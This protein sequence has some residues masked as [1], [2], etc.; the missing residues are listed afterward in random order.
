[1]TFGRRQVLAM[2]AAGQLTTDDADR[3]ITALDRLDEPGRALAR[4]TPSATPPRYLRV[5]IDMHEEGEAQSKVNA[6]VPLRVLRAGGTL[7]PRI[8]PQAPQEL[9][10][11]TG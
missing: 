4:T 2:L 1:M 5:L 8:P 3:L 7:A 6:R 11:P 10:R 9:N